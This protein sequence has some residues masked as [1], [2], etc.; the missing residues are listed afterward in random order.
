[1]LQSND[2]SMSFTWADSNVRVYEI[3]GNQGSNKSKEFKFYLRQLIDLRWVDPEL[4]KIPFIMM[5]DN[6]GIH[7]SDEVKEF[8]CKSKLRSINIVPYSLMLNPCKKLLVTTKSN[9]RKLQSEGR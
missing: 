9:L 4:D 8:I 7:T 5:Y 6:A 1:M 3:L 2:F